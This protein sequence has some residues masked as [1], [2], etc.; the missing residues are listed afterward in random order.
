MGN[1]IFLINN[2]SKAMKKGKLFESFVSMIQESYRDNPNTV[3][4]KNHK[5]KNTSDEDREFDIVIKSSVNG[6]EMT[7]VVECKDYSRKVEAEKIEAF[8]A[9]CAR[10]PGISKMVF[11]SKNGFQSGAKSAAKAF[12]IEIFEFGELNDSEIQK[13]I[14]EFRLTQLHIDRSVTNVRLVMEGDPGDISS[15]NCYMFSYQKSDEKYNVEDVI[16]YMLLEEQNHILNE[17][18]KLWN[19]HKGDN[20]S[21]TIEF[22][23]AKELT[24]M[25]LYLVDSESDYK[26]QRILVTCRYTFTEQEVIYDAANSYINSKSEEAKINLLNTTSVDAGMRLT[27]IKNHDKASNLQ[28]FVTKPDGSPL[29]AIPLLFIPEGLEVR[30]SYV[31]NSKD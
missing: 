14:G 4:L 24:N 30:H 17:A 23:L 16:K 12:N 2:L 9:K 15:S 7:I 19:L 13:W 28:I 3:I 6:Y 22:E 21:V 29:D 1:T 27:I 11:V 31:S 5:L 18:N 8:H 26:L 25:G 20:E 10:V